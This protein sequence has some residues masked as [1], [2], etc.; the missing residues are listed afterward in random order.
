VRFKE[1]IDECE[2]KHDFERMLKGNFKIILKMCARHP[3]HAQALIDEL[4]GKLTADT[5][6]INQIRG[7]LREE[8]YENV[9]NANYYREMKKHVVKSMN[10]HHHMMSN[11]H[12]QRANLDR[13]ANEEAN[14]P[15]TMTQG[16][17]LGKSTGILRDDM[18]N[19]PI[20]MGMGM[21][22]A[23][24]GSLLLEQETEESAGFYEK[25]VKYQ[26]IQEVIESRS[27]IRDM[28]TF[29]SKFLNQGEMSHQISELKR[30][31]ESRIN[32]LKK[33]L[34]ETK[35]ELKRVQNGVGGETVGKDQKERSKQL[36][37]MSA[38]MKREMEKSEGTENLYRDARSGLETIA[39][40]IGIPHP[41]PDTSVHE[42]VNQ[43]ESVMEILMEEKDKS[44][45]KKAEAVA[46]A[47]N[48]NTSTQNARKFTMLGSDLTQRPP[49]LEAALKVY[50]ISKSK[51]ASRL[52]GGPVG[53][54]K[55]LAG[56]VDAHGRGHG[57][58][59]H[60]NVKEGRKL[61]KSTSSKALR[62]QERRIKRMGVPQRD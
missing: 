37:V 54:S 38:R 40:V 26:K 5:N 12:E 48:N 7:L 29:I 13:A 15:R 33:E 25:A 53:K 23:G 31:S 56:E 39:L 21:N 9:A 51:V 46:E 22:L 2:L 43:I 34:V 57:G 50:Q 27:G 42:I 6:L 30:G 49:E 60:S 32:S 16:T 1:E 4:E 41:H 58:L 18:A 24:E 19:S 61:T 36:G 11:R 44:Q 10:L 59:E 35:E 3:A 62:A 45:Q 8:T 47:T 20:P 55:M 14:R 28:E 17:N 52:V